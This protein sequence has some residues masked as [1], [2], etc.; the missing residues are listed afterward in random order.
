MAVI[1]TIKSKDYLNHVYL[2]LNTC[3]KKSCLNIEG[4]NNYKDLQWFCI[5]TVVFIPA[6]IFWK[7][8]SEL[9]KSSMLT[10]GGGLQ[11]INKL[12]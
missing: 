3:Q 2:T 5:V 11:C 10:M 4:K 12:T 9:L 7:G 6:S 8:N 1:T